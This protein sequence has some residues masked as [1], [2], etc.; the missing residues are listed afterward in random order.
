MPAGPRG[1][2][3]EVY[4]IAPQA[5]YA[6]L[7]T[8]QIDV[9]SSEEKNARDIVRLHGLLR[10]LETHWVGTDDGGGGG[11]GSD[12]RGSGSGG[13]AGSG[14]RGSAP[15]AM[16]TGPAG[17]VA[18]AA[19]KVKSSSSVK[20]KIKEVKSSVKS[21]LA[22]GS[23]SGGESMASVLLRRRGRK[24]TLARWGLAE[25]S[26]LLFTVTLYANLAHSLTRSP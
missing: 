11:G 8:Y 15:R 13:N 7:R 12:G 14:A 16:F 2:L 26:V 1:G 22:E 10:E 20:V 21:L 23:G 5:L 18:A 17:R 25:V 9:D 6:K 3:D 4:R 19:P 24:E